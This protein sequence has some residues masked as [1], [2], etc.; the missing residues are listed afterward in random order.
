MAT[1]IYQAFLDHLKLREGYR[2]NVYLD[3]LGNPTCGVGHVLTSEEQTK[4]ATGDVVK[5]NVID[6]WL[7]E[8]AQN[9]WFSAIQ[10]LNDLGLNN[11][12]F[13]LALGSVNF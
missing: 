11:L 8:D 2:D 7:S 13:L 3:T 10:Q 1:R 9:A 4:F 6:N 5:A 12:D